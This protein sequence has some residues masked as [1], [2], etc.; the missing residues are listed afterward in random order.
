MYQ[1]NLQA[2]KYLYVSL[3]NNFFAVFCGG[4]L[5]V[6]SLCNC[7]VCPP[8]HLKSGPGQEMTYAIS[9]R[10]RFVI[11]NCLKKFLNVSHLS[12]TLFIL[13]SYTAFL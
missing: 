11:H 13:L 12:E 5:V 8:A 3:R 9:T 10:L 7:P 6:K 1:P 2:K 4:P